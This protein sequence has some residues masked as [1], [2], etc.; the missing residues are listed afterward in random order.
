ME[1]VQAVQAEQG[2]EAGDALDRALRESFYVRGE[3]L[4]TPATIL[5]AAQR[6]STVDRDDLTAALESGKYRRNLYRDQRTAVAEGVLGSPHLFTRSGW[7]AHNPG[8]R[9]HW[10]HDGSGRRPV[11]DAHDPTWVRRIGSGNTDIAAGENDA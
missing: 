5:G 6:C 8:I 11:I 9:F 3:C 7:S 4:A 10:E 1:A 2:P